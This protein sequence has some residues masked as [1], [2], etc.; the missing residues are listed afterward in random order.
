MPNLPSR[1]VAAAF[2]ALTLACAQSDSENVPGDRAPIPIGTAARAAAESAATRPA[3]GSAAAHVVDSTAL[4]QANP[5]TPCTGPGCASDTAAIPSVPA[6]EYDGEIQA[7]D[8]AR[9]ALATI[10]AV[11]IETGQCPGEGCYKGVQWVVRAKAVVLYAE[12][13]ANSAVVATLEPHTI[14][15]AVG[16]LVRTVP[17]PFIVTRAMSVDGRQGQTMVRGDYVP[18]DTLWVLRYLGEG[19]YRVRLSSGAVVDDYNLEFSA[20]GGSYGK[21]CERHP[22]CWGVLAAELAIDRWMRLRAPNGREG[23]TQDFDAF[24]IPD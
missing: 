12:P 8:P 21:R 16:R 4:A 20:G 5:L 24:I 2:A 7:P 3:A 1:L 18:G 6:A 9:G 13:A 19:H 15:T 14:A 22:A 11:D 10:P 23:W 17:Q